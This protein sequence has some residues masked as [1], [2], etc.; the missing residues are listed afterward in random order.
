MV[1]QAVRDR[2]GAMIE[3]GGSDH[4]LKGFRDPVTLFRA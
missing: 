3:G 2:S 1:T 4:L